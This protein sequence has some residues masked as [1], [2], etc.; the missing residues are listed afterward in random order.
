MSKV[1]SIRVEDEVYDRVEGYARRWKLTKQDL[2]YSVLMGSM[3]KW[4]QKALG[5]T[6]LCKRPKLYQR[7]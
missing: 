1:L 5:I 6:V 2:L 4:E 3:S 7:G